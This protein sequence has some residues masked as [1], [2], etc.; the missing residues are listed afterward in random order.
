MARKNRRVQKPYPAPPIEFE[1]KGQTHHV[2]IRDLHGSELAQF[3]GLTSD[4]DILSQFSTISRFIQFF[5]YSI[6]GKPPEHFPIAVQAEAG[7]VAQ[8]NF[9]EAW[10]AVDSGSTIEEPI[11]AT[12]DSPP[13][14]APSTD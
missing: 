2:R 8:N 12:D 14:S 7:R 5:V 3:A 9:L 10:A 11:P 4:G 13:A 6:D 1:F